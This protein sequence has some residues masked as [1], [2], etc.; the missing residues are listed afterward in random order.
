MCATNLNSR[1]QLAPI[2]EGLRRFMHPPAWLSA[3]VDTERICAELTASV[4]EFAR[5]DLALTECKVKR[6]RLKRGQNGWT[7]QYELVVERP[8]D[9][10]P[11]VEMVGARLIPPGFPEPAAVG[12]KGEFGAEG[13]R[14]YLPGLRLDLE[15]QLHDPA[16]PALSILTDMGEA[17]DLIGRSLRARSGAYSGVEI[18][19]VSIKSMRYKP[20]S[21]ASIV[22]Q[23][24]YPADTE[25]KGAR[26][27]HIVVAKTYSGS[28]G[29]HAYRGM[30]ALWESPLASG[31]VVTIAEPLA[32]IPE[33][34]VLLQGPI[35]GEST[36]EDLVEAAVDTGAPGAEQELDHYMRKTAVGLA[37]LH[38][39]GVRYGETI[40]WA[41]ELADVQDVIERLAVPL[42]ELSG[43]ATPLLDYLLS[44]DARHAPDAARPSHRAFRP[45]QVLLHEGSV[46]FID[47]DGFCQAE[48]ALDLSRFVRK[49]KALGMDALEERATREGMRPS[50]SERLAR[51]ARMD[52]LSD[53][54]LS[55]YEA[56]VPVS[57]GR[58]AL[59]EALDL[60]TL[61]LYCWTK[62]EPER[63]PVNML[64][65]EHHLQTG[66]AE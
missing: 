5:G 36:L 8:G 11:Q 22:Y 10:A 65:L 21:R 6:L 51:A 45:A 64:L 26:W 19:A 17:R 30:Q 23:V 4:P 20:G 58:V 3:A 16:L 35:P 39:S 24:E 12:S 34:R 42:P 28:K 49:T 44:L 31:E 13:W 38:T 14:C 43:A 2:F 63:L 32:Y 1:E 53:M 33:L 61:L 29:E 40:T 52:A 62:V 60:L 50:E 9:S 18:K 37:A 25:D 57:R 27:P 56:G 47:F 7:G 55:A 46:G 66:L 48:P 54:F 15:A 59:W 41:D